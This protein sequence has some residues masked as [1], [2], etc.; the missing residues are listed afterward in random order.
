MKT[1]RTYLTTIMFCT[2]C[3][4][5]WASEENNHTKS[6]ADAIRL[7]TTTRFD[8]VN[9]FKP[10]HP[11]VRDSLGFDI[12]MAP[13]IIQEAPS[14]EPADRFGFVTADSSGH[15]H[16]DSTRPVVYYS[17]SYVLLGENVYPQIFY[18]WFYDNGKT[19]DSGE[20]MKISVQGIRLTME[21]T[22]FPEIIEVLTDTS[23]MRILYV[24]STLE[25]AAL[26]LFGKPLPG[27][28]YSVERSE[29][30]IAD[31]VVA[32]LIKNGPEPSGPFVYIQ[33][34]SHDITALLC[35][36]EMAQFQDIEGDIL[37]E[38]LPMEELK[39]VGVD[40]MVWSRE[41]LNNK[42][43]RSELETDWLKSALRLPPEF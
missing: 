3:L 1:I 38:L 23:N 29:K 21:S 12:Y 19:V 37:Y 26:D 9:L 10:I 8:L 32:R 11:K 14:G 33:S 16:I 39:K 27:R 41:I 6:L 2:C 36:C 28:K 4:C 30:D 42:S 7:R 22:G 43:L 17:Q 24:S 5:A 20:D 13:L 18:L 25:K 34:C 15:A 31:S 35:R 40:D